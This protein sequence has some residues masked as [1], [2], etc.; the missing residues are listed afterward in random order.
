MFKMWLRCSGCFFF[1]W[2]N[3]SRGQCSPR[4]SRSGGFVGV[5]CSE[6]FSGEG[7]VQ[8]GIVQERG[9]GPNRWEAQQAASITTV[10]GAAPWPG[11]RLTKVLSQIWSRCVKT[12]FYGCRCT[13][14]IFRFSAKFLLFSTKI[15]ALHVQKT[16]NIENIMYT[17]HTLCIS[18]YYHVN[19]L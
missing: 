16:N 3:S 13:K 12:G 7:S 9:V 4:Q 19:I 8:T 18:W 10:S 1:N 2:T 6:V 5:H 15:W 11:P 17:S 14:Q